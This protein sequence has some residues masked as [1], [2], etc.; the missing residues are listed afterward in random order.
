M[1]EADKKYAC[2]LCPFKGEKRHK[3]DFHIKHVHLLDT[4]SELTT[5]LFT[6]ILLIDLESSRILLNLRFLQKV[7]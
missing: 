4:R 7:H 5:K 1:T 3:L 2:E 6:T